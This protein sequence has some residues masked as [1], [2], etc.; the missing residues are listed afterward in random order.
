MRIGQVQPIRRRAGVHA[1]LETSS[2]SAARP[3]SFS[4][5]ATGSAPSASRLART[6]MEASGTSAPIKIPGFNHG[7]GCRGTSEVFLQVHARIQAGDLVGVAVEGQRGPP[8][9]VADATLGGLAPARVVDGGVDVGV[10]AV[11]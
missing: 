7:Y 5:L 1:R 2:T 11:L 10:E 8:T 4:I 6:T 3:S 9:E